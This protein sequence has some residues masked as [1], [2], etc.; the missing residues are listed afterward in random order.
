MTTN[1][2]LKRPGG[3]Y[4]ARMKIPA[5]LVDHYGQT[6]H[7]KGL[8]TKELTEA[9][10]RMW[11][12]VDQWRRDHDDIRTRRTLTDA[13]NADAVWQHYTSTL[14]R[15]EQARQMMPTAAD[16]EAFTDPFDKLVA[17]KAREIDANARRVKLDHMRKHL[18]AGETVLINHEVDAYTDQHKLLLNDADRADLARKMMRAE[19]EA[20][21]ATVKRDGG[22]YTHIPADPIVKPSS[23]ARAEKAAPGESVMEL[24]DRYARERGKTIKA[25]TLNQARRDIGTYVDMVG[26]GF[27]ASKIDKRTVGEWKAL[28]L[29]YPVKA[30]ET[31]DFAGM[32]IVEIVRHNAKIGK[33]VIS[34]K[35]V[36]RYL[37]GMSG[38]CRWLS[39]HGII[40]ANP[41]ADMFLDKPDDDDDEKEVFTTDQMNTL[42]K[43]PLF[44][45]CL[46]DGSPR[47][48]SQK[49]N[50]MIRDHRYWVP[51]VMLYSGARPGEIAQLLVDDV[52]QED[53]VWIMHITNTGKGDKSVKNKSSRRV[54]PVHSELVKLG[55][56]DYHAATKRAGEARLFP[57]A[58]RNERGQMIADFSRDFGRYLECIGVK[59]GRGV[60][61][62]SL[63]HG[64][65]DALR[66]AGYLNV[67]FGFLLGHSSGTKIT[68]G[69]GVLAEGTLKQR[70]ELVEKVAYPGLNLP[71]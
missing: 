2:L 22:D 5:D 68:K 4:A 16:L 54:V 45:G 33:P 7:V 65:T 18:A 63:R 47:D 70:V 23:G 67:Q 42:F 57:N 28:L 61:L 31:K 3:G 15:D 9:K 12:M 48:W 35:T 25:D 19:I 32:S 17:S 34:D 41:V 24:F 39:A 43:S 46:R 27:P 71:F 58:E 59:S 20:L 13:D 21:E 52:R 62:Y 10:R 30:S 6:H 66:R 26:H 8:S 56:L 11:I 36:N 50:V 69:Y 14:D 38:F 64:F 55:F 51:L 49:G 53:G 40:A 60:S 37:S 29:Q 44:T 1:Y